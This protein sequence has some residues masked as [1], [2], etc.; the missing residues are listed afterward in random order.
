MRW[1][2]D[3]DDF[4]TVRAMAERARGL[5]DPLRSIV[6]ATGVVRRKDEAALA[7]LALPVDE[8]VASDDLATLSRAIGGVRHAGSSAWKFHG[9][10]V[11][12]AYG[13]P[14]IAMATT[15]KNRN[16]LRR[17]GRPGCCAPS[18]IRAC[19]S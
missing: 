16:L 18:T 14:S 10:V 15:D 13:V 6:L 7:R 2:N 8:T 3:H 12:T 5:G 1:R 11:A 17:L 19:L 9:T 4:A